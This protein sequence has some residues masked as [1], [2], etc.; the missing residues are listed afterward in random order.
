MSDDTYDDSAPNRSGASR[1]GRPLSL[2]TLRRATRWETLA[3]LAVL[4]VCVLAFA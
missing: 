2:S 3:V 4:L 1:S